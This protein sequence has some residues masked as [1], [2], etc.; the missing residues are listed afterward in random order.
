MLV[1][2]LGLSAQQ[3]PAP[4]VTEPGARLDPSG[5]RYQRPLVAGE[6]GL[7]TLT[8]D[9]AALA[10]SQGPL[11][12]FADVRVVDAGNAQIPYVLERRGERLSLDLALRAATPQTRELQEG[13]G[14][15]RS[16]YALTLPFEHLPGPVI[17][18]ATSGTVFRRPV[19]LGV[20]RP[21]DRSRREAA[22]EQLTQTVW[23]H[24]DATIPAPP[25]ELA[26]P[27]ERSRELLLIVD[28]GDNRPL[29]IT[30]ARLL[31]PGWQL[32]FHRP[33]GPLRLLYGKDDITEPHYDVAVL[34]PSAMRG[35]AREAAAEPE[36][37]TEPPAA[38]VSPRAFWV[39]LAVAVLLLLGVLVRLISSGTEPPPSPPVP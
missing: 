18:L 33:P 12:S 29:P 30:A 21:P 14:S 19:Q 28:E 16:F 5:F 35:E 6:P 17:A 4:A 13:R 37:A 27:F 25:L 23:E 7:V 26:L 34:A 8:L 38:L 2:S 11:R 9:A 24:R 1:A 39:G 36:R 20:E 32:R 15:Q 10:H 31:L 3:A 22:F